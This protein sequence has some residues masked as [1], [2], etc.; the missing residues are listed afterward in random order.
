MKTPTKVDPIFKVLSD[1][2]PTRVRDICITLIAES[3]AKSSPVAPKLSRDGGANLRHFVTVTRIIALFILMIAA[4]ARAAEPT[5]ASPAPASGAKMLHASV[6]TRKDGPPTKAFP[7]GTPKIYGLWKGNSL[8]AGDLVRVVWIAESFGYQRKDAKITE[9]AA[10]AYKPDD[11][12]VFSLV[13]PDG[14][15][16]IGRYRLEFYVRTK[17]VET[18]RFLIEPD[19]TVEVR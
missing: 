14:G 8:K 15:W 9:A 7:S 19:V 17:L 4:A 2:K 16:P 13:R 11:D 1:N 5:A 3:V 12:G 10:T 6:T 18:V